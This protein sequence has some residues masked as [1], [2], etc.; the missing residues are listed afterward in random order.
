[1]T[2][3][4]PYSPAIIAA[5]QSKLVTAVKAV[6]QISSDCD[7]AMGMAVSEP[8][9]LLTALAARVE[10]EALS[11][12]RLWYFHSLSHAAD[13]VLRYELLDRIRPHCMFLSKV[14]R[15][16][17][18]RGD[19]DGHEPIEFVPTGFS[20]FFPAAQR[21]RADRYFH[22]DRFADGSEWLVHVRD[23]Q[24]LWHHSRPQR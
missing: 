8:P 3:E 23:Q 4:H 17:I 18:Q 13:S 10:E 1:M 7:V 6:S 5:Y 15:A 24:R 12:V 19:V 2:G 21:N 9:A 16:L 22:H 14:E 20:D 11:A